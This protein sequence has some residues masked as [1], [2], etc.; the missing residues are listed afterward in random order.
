MEVDNSAGAVDGAAL[1][2][3]LCP[4]SLLAATLFQMV[5]AGGAAAAAEADDAKCEERTPEFEPLFSFGR[6]LCSLL[7][8]EP[9]GRCRRRCTD[10]RGGGTHIR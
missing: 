6:S 8:L 9:L 2:S 3:D 4:P 7:E 10:L 1:E 5:L